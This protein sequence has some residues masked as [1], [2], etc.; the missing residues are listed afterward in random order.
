[1]LDP[2]KPP[3][4]P[5]G[6][7]S[8]SA[9]D[10]LNLDPTVDEFFNRLHP[11]MRRPLP[12]QEAIADALQTMQRLAA[13]AAS[14]TGTRP[15]AGVSSVCHTCGHQN[16]PGNQFCGMCGLPLAAPGANPSAGAIPSS[17]GMPAESASLPAG[18]HH[19]HHHYHHYL[20]PGQDP[21]AAYLPSAAPGNV[22][23]SKL[24]APGSSG[25]MSRVEAAVRKVMQDWTQACNMRQ[26]DDLVSTYSPDALV[27]RP[28]H[29]AVRGAAAIREYFFAALDSGLGEVEIDP[30]RVDVIGDVAYEAGR[31][32]MLV[33][34]AVGKRREER[35]KYL[36]TLA[37]Q[38]NGEWRIVSDCWSTDLN[39]EKPADTAPKPPPVPLSPLKPPPPKK[40]P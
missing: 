37:R 24:R 11:D 14:E 28:N 34:V 15:A 32:K 10:N 23:P 20:A 29:P 21:S 38:P 1:M 8:P 13:E 25:T 35:G 39:L 6:N 9:G 16:R 36:A 7:P 26:L 5:S 40:A 18:Q 19:Y 22:P 3:S 27:L 17:S 31:C 30:L 2:K 4:P 12:T 33:P